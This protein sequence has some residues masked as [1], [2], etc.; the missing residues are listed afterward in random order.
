[1]HVTVPCT[2]AARG[3]LEREG[4]LLCLWPRVCGVAI[5]RLLRAGGRTSVS[6]QLRVTV[7]ASKQG[8]FHT[9]MSE[10]KIILVTGYGGW[11][12]HDVN[13]SALLAEMVTGLKVGAGAYRIVTDVLPVHW[14][15][16]PAKLISLIKQYK[17]KAIVCLGLAGG[18]TGVRVERVAVNLS[19]GADNAE[20]KREDGPLDESGPDALLATLPT[21]K[22]V[23]AIVDAG[24]PAA[25][26]MS[27][28][29]YLCNAAMYTAIHHGGGVPAGFIHV[30]IAITTCRAAC[31]CA[32]VA[33]CGLT[34]CCVYTRTAC[35]HQIPNTPELVVAEARATGSVAQQSS[36][37]LDVLN[38]RLLPA[39]CSW[40]RM[41]SPAT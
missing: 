11:A 9:V 36:M 38:S 24:V 6:S 16:W 30:R 22:M 8:D 4:P 29:T 1:M 13:P 18:S 39:S 27:A 21:R 23:K 5:S 3:A 40:Q 26:S 41:R 19:N 2:R 15:E 28:G 7:L 17:P 31:A 25:P 34:C 20:L 32:L 35:N 37:S 33:L 14:I 10:E 12:N